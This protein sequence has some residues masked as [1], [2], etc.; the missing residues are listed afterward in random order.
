MLGRWNSRYAFLTFAADHG[1]YTGCEAH[2]NGDSG[3]YPG[4]ASPQHGKRHAIEITG[5]RSHHNFAGLGGSAGNSL[6]VHDNEFDDNTIGV[7]LDSYAAGHPGMPQGYSVFTGNR[8]HDNNQDFYRYYRDG[9]CYKPRDQRGYDQGV[10]CPVIGGP[11]GTGIL[12]AGGNHNVIRGNWIY[13]NW[14]TGTMQFWVP[15]T[16]RG[17]NDPAK[18]FDTSHFNRYTDNHLGRSPDGAIARN[19]LDF[20]WDGEGTGNCW[21]HNTPAGGTVTSD[22]VLLPNCALPPVF[23]PP[24]PAKTAALLACT[25]WTRDNPDPPGCDWTTKPPKPSSTNRMIP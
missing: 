20:W 10:V 6:W 14:R 11:I 18:F 8:I 4:A 17:E 13:D 22:P 1:L 23:T 2:G 7:G 3:L 21:Q 12:I 16:L 25:G 15:A 5:C 9:T 24:D 19:G